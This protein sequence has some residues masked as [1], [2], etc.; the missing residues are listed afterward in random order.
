MREEMHARLE[1]L[2]K[3]FETGQAELEKV[4]KQRTYVRE[5][6]LRIS[7]AIQVLEELLAKEQTLKQRNGADPGEVRTTPA[8]ATDMDESA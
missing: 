5:T 7:G 1:A 3:E 4:E 6:V 8:Q 2:K